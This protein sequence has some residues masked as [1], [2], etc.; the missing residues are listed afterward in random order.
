MTK[1][2]PAEPWRACPPQVADVI[3]P[4]LP[5]RSPTTS[6][7]RSPREVP[8]YARPLEGS[9]GR[10]V[11]AGVSEA[12]RQFVALIRDPDARPRA[13]AARSTSALGRGELRAGPHASTRSSPP[14]GWA[15][16]SPGG[17][18][19]RRA[20][21]PASTPRT[22]SLLAESI[23]AYIDELSAD[24]VEGYAEARSRARGR[25]R[26]AARASCSRCCCASRPPT[27]PSCARPPRPRAGRCPA[28]PRRSPAPRTSSTGCAPAAAPTRS[29][30]PLDGLGCAVIP[31]PAGPGRRGGSSARAA[32]AAALGPGAAARELAALVGA[33]AQRRS[34]RSTAGAIARGGLLR[35]DDHLADAAAPRGAAPL[36]SGSPRGGSR[37]S[38]SS[39]RGHASGWR[40]RR[41][42][43]SQQQ[44]N[45]AAMA[46]A[47]HVHPQTARYRLRAAARAARRPAR[48]PRRALRARAGATSAPRGRRVGRAGRRTAHAPPRH[49]PG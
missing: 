17:G 27:T 32:T 26:A 36:A 47:L 33:G 44:G 34:R 28:A 15:P 19:P 7:P 18:S 5:A 10:G 6:S 9:F 48:R 38:R 21:R 37:R 29:T 16:G 42:P 31:D 24:S 39:P 11:R 4:E 2:A 20:A 49:R 22:L 8:E 45:A 25:A 40:R 30:S 14:T 1:T 35:A 23:F 3:E 46:R 12:L 13:R 43:T 41:S